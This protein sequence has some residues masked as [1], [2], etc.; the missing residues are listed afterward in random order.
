MSLYLPDQKLGSHSEP[1]STSESHKFML[2]G[3]KTGTMRR[4]HSWVFR[5]ESHETM[6]SWY[7]DIESL[8]SKTGEAR[9]AF[10]RR[11]T[12]TTSGNSVAESSRWSELMEDEDEADRTPYSR[13]SAVLNP[14]RPVSE[15]RQPGGRFPSDVQI[16]RHLQVPL[17]P[18]SGESSGDRDLLAA[19]GSSGPD[20]STTPL[21]DDGRPSLSDRG[22][23]SP[24]GVNGAP[25]RPASYYGDWIGPA[26]VGA[27]QQEKPSN[28]KN[29]NS[30]RS[31][32]ENRN[33]HASSDTNLIA[34]AGV[35]FPQEP[36]TVG[37]RARRES[38]STAPTTTNMTDLTNN[39]APTVPTSIDDTQ[40][41]S[42]ANL[43]DPDKRQ[44]VDEMPQD[45]QTPSA[46]K[47]DG[48]AVGGLSVR[49]LSPA[50]SASNVVDSP[51]AM[52][53]E[54]KPAPTTGT[55]ATTGTT[56]TGRTKGSVSTL[57][58]KIPGHYP[59]PNVAV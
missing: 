35:M 37:R 36:S 31:E 8:I 41:I 25:P 46:N 58:L 7:E 2:K 29:P 47:L 24:A 32:S 48:A 40:D 59:P 5:A 51:A 26:A 43:V 30:L 34:T 33:N 28:T 15:P 39:T 23:G 16:D 21:N 27:R 50:R 6:M 38:A 22:T 44:L 49:N 56:T 17:S 20:R 19:V 14:E 54:L 55:T 13:Q 12:R 57:E 9:N 10:V 53:E 4:G 11:H 18:S 42:P 52:G 45:G 3:R 1:D